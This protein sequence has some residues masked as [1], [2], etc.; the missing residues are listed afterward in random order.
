MINL[1]M[2]FTVPLSK[3]FQF[4]VHLLLLC[5]SLYKSRAWNT[6]V[7]KDMPFA[8]PVGLLLEIGITMC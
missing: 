7:Q 4:S 8:F 3:I 1:I 6:L 5:T 2:H